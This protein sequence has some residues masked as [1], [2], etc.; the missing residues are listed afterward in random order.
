[1]K[2]LRWLPMHAFERFSVSVHGGAAFVP[3][4]VEGFG[5]HEDY[6]KAAVTDGEDANPYQVG[7]FRFF[8]DCGLWFMLCCPEEDGP[9]YKTL[10][11]LLGMSGIGE[12]FDDQTEWLHDALAQENSSYLLLTTALPEKEY[13][14]SVLDGAYY[15][16]TRRG[17]FI[18]SETYAAEPQKK[19]TQYFLAAGSVLKRKFSGGLFNVGE[20]GKHPV[21]RYSAPVLLG[22]S[23]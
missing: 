13:L 14:E 8:E 17:G 18:Q 7:V 15:Q 4:T 3:E 22:V 5:V 23:L 20:S 9:Y 11:R 10:L 19:D 21:Y 12:P 16:L 1:M 2:K 6:T